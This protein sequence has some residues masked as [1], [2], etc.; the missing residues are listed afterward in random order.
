MLFIC[1]LIMHISTEGCF[2]LIL[3]TSFIKFPRTY[4]DFHVWYIIFDSSVQITW[5]TR[6]LSCILSLT[7]CDFCGVRIWSLK[8]YW[9]VCFSARPC[10]WGRPPS[11]L[12]IYI[13][14]NLEIQ[15]LDHPH[16]AY[17]LKGLSIETSLNQK[18]LSFFFQSPY[19]PFYAW[20]F[21][22]R[23]E[24]WYRMHLFPTGYK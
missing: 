19:E 20:E 23:L 4:I 10:P 1:T 18:I 3:L 17:W 22:W 8:Q 12:P 24:N 5:A 14:H 6:I 13:L 9:S 16:I 15:P 7:S 2:V 11:H 21:K